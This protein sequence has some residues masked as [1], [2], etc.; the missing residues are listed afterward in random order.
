M[1]AHSLRLSADPALLS[2]FH[3]LGR[4]EFLSNRHNDWSTCR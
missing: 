1:G 3:Y 2:G 4:D